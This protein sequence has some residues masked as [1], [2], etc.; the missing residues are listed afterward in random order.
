MALDPRIEAIRASF[1]LDRSDFWELPKKKGT[2]LV[3][4]SALEVVAA[5]S[6]IMF[7]NPIII[8]ANGAEGVAAL[9]VRGEMPDGRAVWSIGEAN[10]KNCRNAYPWAMA[11]KRAVDRVILKLVGIHGLVYSEDEMADDARPAPQVASGEPEQAKV[12]VSDQREIYAAMRDE[13]DACETL[14]DL[15]VFWRSPAAQAEFKKLKPDW[16]TQIT[17]HKD[18]RKAALSVPVGNPPRVAPSFDHMETAR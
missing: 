3:K 12:K 15:A 18:A 14:D 4:H 11:E 16:A 5:K 9:S 2:W 17:E 13:I 6:G 8:E 1:G 7:D 10:P